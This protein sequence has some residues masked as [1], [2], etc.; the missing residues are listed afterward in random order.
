MK[1]VFVLGSSDP[2]MQEIERVVKAAGHEVLYATVRAMRARAAQAAEANGVSGLLPPNTPIVTVECA[3]LGLCPDVVIDH[4]APGDPGY[5]CGPDR[6]LEGSSLGQTLRLLGITPSKEQLLIAAS[7]H[8]PTQAYAGLCPG[9]SPKDLAD[10]RR[11]SRAERRRVTPAEME[12]AILAAKDFL[13]TSAERVEFCGHP[14]P[15]VVDKRTSSEVSEASAR[16]GIPFMYQERDED[17][18]T[19]F[20]IVGAGPELVAAWMRDCG[21]QGVYGNPYRGYAGG[22]SPR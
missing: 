18:R 9:V 7:D 16:F 6:F 17:G 8:C 15:W 11:A 5:A 19:K 1:Y 10:W 20:G 4:H 22:Y 3:V 2:E 12:S 14:F 13:T 21:L